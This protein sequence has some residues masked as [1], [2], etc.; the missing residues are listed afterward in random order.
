MATISACIFD[1]DGV[2]VD[3]ARYHFIAWKELAK[4]WDIDLTTEENE[5]LKGVSRV[6]SLRHIIGLADIQLSN[7]EIDRYCT[8]KNAHYLSLISDMDDSELLPGVKE[9][10]EELTQLN[11]KIGL[12]SASKNAPHIIKKT[13]IDHYFQAVVSGNDVVNSKPHPEVFLNG[14]EILNVAPV[15]TIVFEDSQKGIEAANRGNFISVGI[16]DPHDLGKADI[17]IPGFEHHSYETI[18]NTLAQQI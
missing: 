3:T 12:G 13:A 2:I 4:T 14:A 7:D 9:L 8:E 17:V 5:K 11:I 15:E 16:G 6:E 18:V 1:L 10:L